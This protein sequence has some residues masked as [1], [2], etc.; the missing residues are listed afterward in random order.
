MEQSS[1]ELM[2]TKQ[3]SDQVD[4]A[5]DGTEPFFVFIFCEINRFN[6]EINCV[7]SARFSFQVRSF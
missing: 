4:E 7:E 2:K 3:S 5:L 6:L 1:P